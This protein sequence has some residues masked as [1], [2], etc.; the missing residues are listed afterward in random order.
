VLEITRDS[1]KTLYVNLVAGMS[2]QADFNNRHR[3][4]DGA[5]VLKRGFLRVYRFPADRND[6][7]PP[8]RD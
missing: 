5:E 6:S 3:S 8:V 4:R 7:P 2:A 1:P